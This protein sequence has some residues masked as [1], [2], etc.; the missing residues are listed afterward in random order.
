MK[1]LTLYEQAKKRKNDLFDNSKRISLLNNEKYDIYR[2]GLGLIIDE[3][4]FSKEYK[5]DRAMY[6]IAFNKYKEFN[7][8]F[9]KRFKKEYKEDRK[10]G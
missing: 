2:N 4:K 5:E 3:V 10:Y 8:Y 1:E 7:S 9:I 6:A